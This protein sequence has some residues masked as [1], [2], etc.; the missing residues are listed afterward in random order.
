M[1]PVAPT[2][3]ATHD[4]VPVATPTRPWMGV[5]LAVA[6]GALAAGPVGAVVLGA[7]VVVAPRIVAGRRRARAARRLGDEVA[8][9]FELAA[10]AVRT[11]VAVPEAVASVA[12]TRPG[13]AATLVTELFT[14]GSAAVTSGRD[15]AGPGSTVGVV[16]AIVG[17]VGGTTGGAARGLEAGAMILRERQRA[18]GEV[19][20]GIAQARTSAWLLGGAPV[21]L[22]AIAAVLT[23]GGP[24]ALL[25]HPGALVAV[26]VGIVAE[27]VGLTW[28]RRLVRAV[29]GDPD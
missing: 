6:V 3:T 11:G 17:I 12:V 10:R 16:T 15:G 19:Q 28:T 24:A 27:G 4:D 29:E 2:L 13:P 5:V 8:T 21:V 26:G 9:L 23:P 25:A 18:R 7:G 22:A 20:A 14:P 1:S